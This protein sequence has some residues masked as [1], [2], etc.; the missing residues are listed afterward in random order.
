MSN[1]KSNKVHLVF[2]QTSCLLHIRRSRPSLDVLRDAPSIPHLKPSCD[3]RK[4]FRLRRFHYVGDECPAVGEI[5]ADELIE[6]LVVFLSDIHRMR[7]DSASVIVLLSLVGR[8]SSLAFFP[9]QNVKNY[10]KDGRF[11]VDD[12]STVFICV[13]PV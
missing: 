3:G 4:Y 13:L 12:S 1:M 2:T 11:A 8:S 5:D 6:A 7:V 9:L 10:D